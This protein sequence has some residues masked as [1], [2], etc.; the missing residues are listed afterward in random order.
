MLHFLFQSLHPLISLLHALFHPILPF[1][2]LHQRIFL[3]I[4]LLVAVLDLD[5]QLFVNVV[6]FFE[7]L[8]VNVLLE[9]L[10]VHGNLLG[11]GLDFLFIA[12][13]WL[14]VLLQV[15]Y[16][17]ITHQLHFE[18]FYMFSLLIYLPFCYTMRGLIC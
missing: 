15:G 11:S 17:D 10:L 5:Y 3:L 2:Y 13:E 9:K 12:L 8:G 18:L 1:H 7:N 14:G 16:K 6:S 4:V